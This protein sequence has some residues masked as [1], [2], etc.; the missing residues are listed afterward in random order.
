MPFLHQAS[1]TA[2]AVL[3]L[4]AIAQ[5]TSMLATALVSALVAP[6]SYADSASH[7]K[8]KDRALSWQRSML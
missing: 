1:A 6:V 3:S 8:R 2:I 7:H 4:D 5:Q